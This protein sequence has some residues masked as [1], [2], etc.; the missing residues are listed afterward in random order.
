M[1]ALRGG[2]YC[3]LYGGYVLRKLEW[4]KAKGAEGAEGAEGV[5]AH[6]VSEFCKG[7]LK[8]EGVIQARRAARLKAASWITTIPAPGTVWGLLGAV[9]CCRSPCS[10]LK[11][12]PGGDRRCTDGGQ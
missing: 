8:I 1:R 5:R 2:R 4:W 9:G 3:T 6:S 12:G 10:G 7:S 11:P